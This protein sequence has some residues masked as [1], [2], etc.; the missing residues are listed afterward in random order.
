LLLPI[1]SKFIDLLNRYLLLHTYISCARRPAAIHTRMRIVSTQ[2]PVAVY[3]TSHYRQD[4]VSLSAAWFSDDGSLHGVGAHNGGSPRYTDRSG[5]CLSVSADAVAETWIVTPS[6][7]IT[8]KLCTRPSGRPAAR[9][10]ALSRVHTN[11]PSADPTQPNPAQR[12]ASRVRCSAAAERGQS[13]DR[14]PAPPQPR[15]HL[16]LYLSFS[17]FIIHCRPPISVMELQTVDWP[18]AAIC[19]LT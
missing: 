10:D 7:S 11:R 6:L 3:E 16:L 5:S 1:I 9:I 17:V 8:S 18:T 19:C 12:G 4:M 2:R 13:I 15:V 14:P